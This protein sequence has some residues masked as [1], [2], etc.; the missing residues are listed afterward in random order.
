MDV[1]F[2]DV[3]AAD[4]RGAATA[5]ADF[6]QNAIFHDIAHTCFPGLG[7]PRGGGRFTNARRQDRCC[8]VRATARNGRRRPASL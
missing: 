1:E 8:N 3:A 7:S 4:G 5:R 2:D 6:N